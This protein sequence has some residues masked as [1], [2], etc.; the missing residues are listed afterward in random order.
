MRKS[1][2]AKKVT[3]STLSKITL[4]SVS[5]AGEEK[6]PDIALLQDPEKSD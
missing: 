1:K 6:K 5:G 2:Q 3:P 4:Y